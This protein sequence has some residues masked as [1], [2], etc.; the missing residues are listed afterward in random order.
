MT[1]SSDALLVDPD[2]ESIK[3]ERVPVSRHLSPAVIDGQAGPQQQ[4]SGC[5]GDRDSMLL[6]WGLWRADHVEGIPVRCPGCGAGRVWRRRNDRNDHL[7]GALGKTSPSRTERRPRSREP[8]H[9]RWC[10]SGFDRRRAS[11]RPLGR[12]SRSGTLATRRCSRDG[13]EPRMAADLRAPAQQLDIYGVNSSIDR[14]RL[15]RSDLANCNDE[16]I[17]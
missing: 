14:S 16:R 6:R 10:S 15:E 7:A 5:L 4:S 2:K 3:S 11:G 17:R 12:K 8:V 1:A 9:R 13:N